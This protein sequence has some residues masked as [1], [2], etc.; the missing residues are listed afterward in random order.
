ML[1]LPLVRFSFFPANFLTLRCSLFLSILPLFVTMLSFMYNVYEPCNMLP[2]G[3]IVSI[4]VAYF[5]A[6]VNRSYGFPQ[7][8]D[9][10]LNSNGTTLQDPH[11]DALSATP[12]CPERPNFDCFKCHRRLYYP[13]ILLNHD[14]VVFLPL[15]TPVG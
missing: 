8:R 11:N 6:T 9:T 1:M 2:Y 3:P 12:R 5:D 10:Q 13:I 14:P 4:S 15:L 7:Q